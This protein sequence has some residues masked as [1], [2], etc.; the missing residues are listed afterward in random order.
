MEPQGTIAGGVPRGAVF[1]HL[2]A[3]QIAVVSLR[4]SRRATIHSLAVLILGFYLVPKIVK[5]INVRLSELVY[6]DI[7]S[8]QI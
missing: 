7:C 4:S 6:M 1:S 3:L 2:G 8:I 5:W